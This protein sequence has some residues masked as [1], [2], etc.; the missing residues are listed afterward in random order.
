MKATVELTDYELR[1]GA[2]VGVER[3]LE[4]LR[5]G[6]QHRHGFAGE[7]W[8]IHIE[9][10]LAELAFAKAR[11]VFWDA[12][13]R[14]PEDLDGDVGSAQIRSTKRP[15]GCLI[16]H[17]DDPDSAAF[18]L[19][20]QENPRTYSFRGWLRGRDAKQQRWWRTDT[21]RPAFFVPQ[22]YLRPMPS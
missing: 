2:A 4:A 19:I 6:R 8:D 18:V 1:L 17:K 14:R 9:G 21:G 3:Q 22:G 11:A 10:A 16:V 15:S 7:G 12:V 13:V 20:T 5:L